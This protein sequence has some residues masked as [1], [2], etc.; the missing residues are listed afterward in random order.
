MFRFNGG[1]GEGNFSSNETA[2]ILLED[3]LLY[4][5]TVTESDVSPLKTFYGA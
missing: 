4:D 5:H 1:D 2:S 3:C